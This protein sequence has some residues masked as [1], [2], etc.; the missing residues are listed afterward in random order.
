M[1]L[2]IVFFKF[3]IWI[4]IFQKPVEE[5]KAS[6]EI[7]KTD[8]SKLSRRQ[9]LQI[10]EKESPEL[11]NLIDD[12]KSISMQFSAIMFCNF[13][14]FVDKMTLARDFLYPII[15]KHKAGELPKGKAVDFVQTQYGIIL[16]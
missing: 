7:V 8:I 6:E 15:K 5:E 1:L 13:F 11:F 12:Y 9:K 3:I 4:F 2:F 10:L 14:F 16:K